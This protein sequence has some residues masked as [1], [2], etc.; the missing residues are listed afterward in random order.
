MSPGPDGSPAIHSV[1]IPPPLANMVF[2]PATVL[3][4]WRDCSLCIVTGIKIAGDSTSVTG[5][6]QKCFWDHSNHSRAW[7]LTWACTQLHH[8]P[9]MWPWASDALSIFSPGK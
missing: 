5:A 9:S 7:G 6:R 4:L 3:S 2:Q 8:L 1:N